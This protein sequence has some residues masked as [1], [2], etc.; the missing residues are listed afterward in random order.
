[1]YETYFG[2]KEAPFS[3]TPD[4]SYLYLSPSHK[5]ALSHLRYGLQER[6]GFI[7][8][9][10]EVGCGKTTLSRCLLQ[11][12]DD[13]NY[14]T[15]LIM[16]PRIDETQLL[17]EILKELGEKTNRRNHVDLLD[18][19]NTALLDR[20]AKG[21]EIVLVIDEA[22]NLSFEVLEQLR[23]LSNLETDNRK[24]LQI[25]LLGQPEFKQKLKQPRL[26]QLRQRILVY[27]ELRP[28]RN[29]GEAR[30][31]VAHRL[32]KASGRAA[33]MFSYWA[34]RKIFR[35]SRGIPRIINN[36]C[37]KSLLSAYVRTSGRVGYRDVR[38]AIKDLKSL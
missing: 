13:K 8:L 38:R 26:R 35:R 25:I 3:I 17:Y 29:L 36:L 1:M 4:P 33:P 18:R 30:Q 24:L 22:Q 14:A 34:L 7:V 11:E 37:D 16:N 2:F 28:L 19:L 21:Q 31:Y 12:L 10:G 9:V 15:A 20:I 32:H 23:L 6:K 27:Y 5:E